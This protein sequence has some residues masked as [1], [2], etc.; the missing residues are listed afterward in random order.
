M[1]IG[2]PLGARASPPSRRRASR[3]ARSRR[4]PSRRAG[5]ADR[6]AAG[7]ARQKFLVGEAAPLVGI[8]RLVAG[9]ADAALDQP[10][11]GH[12]G[13]HGR[14]PVGELNPGV[15]GVER[16]RRDIQAMPDL[17]PEPF[18]GVDAAA[19]GD[20]LRTKP[21]AE[22]SDPGRLAPARVILPQPALRVEVALPLRVRCERL[23]ARVDRD[24]ARS[25]RIHADAD[26]LRRVEIR[27]ASRLG[28][29]ALDALLEA[30]QIVGRMLT[31]EQAILRSSRM[32]CA[33]EG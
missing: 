31:R 17:R 16:L 30:E 1:A 29:R 19:F 14:N 4:R 2:M 32:P 15:G 3:P 7:R 6:R 33:P 28:E 22:F 12:A 13:E 27:F 20:V 11:V 21:G 10:R 5:R 26:D 23:V 8:E 9:G 25:G 24:R 18:G